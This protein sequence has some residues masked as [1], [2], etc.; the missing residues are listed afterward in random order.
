MVRTHGVFYPE[1]TTR[2]GF[3]ELAASALARHHDSGLLRRAELQLVP[4]PEEI[5]V[6][7]EAGVEWLLERLDGATRRCWVKTF[8]LTDERVTEALVRAH[9]RGV[10]VRVSLNASRSDGSRVNDPAFARLRGAGVAVSWAPAR[11]YVSHEK[12]L[13]LD[14]AG[15]VLTFNLAP[16][17]FTS[18]RGYAVTSHDPALLHELEEGFELDWH[19]RAWPQTPRSLIYSG[20][21]EGTAR[22]RFAE[23]VAETRHELLVQGPKLVD[24]A[25]CAQLLE[26]LGRGVRVCFLSSGRKG[27]SE[28][29]VVEND[30]ALASLQAAGAEVRRL[31]QPRM[32][33]KL[34]LADR[35]RALVGSCN[36]DRSCFELRR[37]LTCCL[38]HPQPVSALAGA[39]DRD[40]HAAD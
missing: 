23:F 18:F 8:K 13:I 37:E 5:A 2:G 15:L 26:A 24:G 31:K 38:T 16:K 33:A 22:A 6:F 32:H 7:P 29:D 35:A 11:F 10:D 36:L 27:L 19:D 21:P 20:G 39:F 3:T 12:S 34:L 14:S 1:K 4:A 30:A 40:W 9:L 25:T 17:S 28:W